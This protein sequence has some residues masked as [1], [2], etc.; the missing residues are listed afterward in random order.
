[1]DQRSGIEEHGAHAHPP[2]LH[3]SL[4]RLSVPSRL[5]MVASLA[6]LLWAAL[7]WASN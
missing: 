3:A 1:M 7:L 6:L 4:W 2:V 5:A